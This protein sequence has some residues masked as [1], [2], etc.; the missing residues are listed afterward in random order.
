[1]R[2]PQ[3]INHYHIEGY[4]FVQKNQASDVVEQ[5]QLNKSSETRVARMCC[6]A[7][8]TDSQAIS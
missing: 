3:N 8:F 2:I 7:K 5:L 1:V 6:V 4:L